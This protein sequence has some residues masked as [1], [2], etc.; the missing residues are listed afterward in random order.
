MVVQEELKRLLPEMVK[1]HLTEAYMKR[2]FTENQSR[3]GTSMARN[4]SEL[5]VTPKDEQ[6]DQ[7][8][9]EPMQNS[10]QGIYGQ[11]KMVKEENSLSKLLSP[12]N[13]LS[14]IYEGVKPI[15]DEEVGPPSIPIQKTNFDFSRMAAVVEATSKRSANASEQTTLSMKMKE[16][17][18]R[19]KLLDRKP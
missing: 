8:V 7:S 14:Y 1:T 13:P 9:P 6:E 3:P 4:M 16:L 11:S 12:E 5:M 18:E 17:E 19:R 15:G 10:D 2:L